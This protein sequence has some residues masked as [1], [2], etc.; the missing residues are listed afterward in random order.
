MLCDTLTLKRPMRYL[1]IIHYLFR[2]VLSPLLL[3]LKVFRR[4]F[5]AGVCGTA[6][7]RQH[8]HLVSC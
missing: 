7:Y 5:A 8:S 2:V 3:R 6:W 4:S 1:F